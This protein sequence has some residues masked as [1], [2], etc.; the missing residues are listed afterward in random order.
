M[1][2]PNARLARMDGDGIQAPALYPNL[3]HFSASTIK[4]LEE[5]ELRVAVISAYNDYLTDFISIAAGRFIAATTIPFWDIDLSIAEVEQCR[6][7][8]HR[9]IIMTQDPRR[10]DLPDLASKHGIGSG[11]RCNTSRCR[12]TSTSD[13]AE[14]GSCS[15]STRN[16]ASMPM[17]LAAVSRL[18]SS[19]IRIVSADTRSVMIVVSPCEY[20]S[21]GC[22]RGLRGANVTTCSRNRVQVSRIRTHLA[23]R[24]PDIHNRDE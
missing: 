15:P 8:G 18:I 16:L 21:I 19:T 12:S 22:A 23:P 1:W 11:P 5:V 24:G 3:A 7:N 9:G 17:P 4:T 14:S 10:F 6:A 20:P 13:R 2:D